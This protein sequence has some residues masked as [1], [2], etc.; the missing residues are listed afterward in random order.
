MPRVSQQQTDQNR[1]AIEKASSRLF[2]EKGLDG[3]SVAEVMAAAG[4]THGGFYGHFSSKDGLAAV[5]CAKAFEQS[6]AR[7]DQRFADLPEPGERRRAYV[8]G[9][10]ATATRDRPGSS[11]TAAALAGDVARA[12]ADAPVRAAYL[13]GVKAMAARLASLQPDAGSPEAGQRALAE[14]ATLVG[15]LLLSRATK[16][17]PISDALLASARAQ[18]L[19]QGAES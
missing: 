11:C 13:D 15:A 4:L 19:Q 16:G 2:R 9:Y 5:A 8:E 18:L 6:G 7:W 12:Q 17:D 14:M 3:V 10:L 1:I